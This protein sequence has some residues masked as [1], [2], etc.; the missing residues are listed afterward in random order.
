M[1]QVTAPAWKLIKDLSK[2]PA[3]VDKND[4]IDHDSDKEFQ[5]TECD[6]RSDYRRK[7]LFHYELAHVAPENFRCEFW[8]GSLGFFNLL[9]VCINFILVTLPKNV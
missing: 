5:C 1:I 2:D 8:Y 4:T 3:Y 6:F 7:Y 9:N